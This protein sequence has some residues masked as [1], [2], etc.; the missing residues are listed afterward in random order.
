MI[1]EILSTNIYHLRVVVLS[2][3]LFKTIV[4]LKYRVSLMEDSPHESIRSLGHPNTVYNPIV[5]AVFGYPIGGIL[6]MRQG[7]VHDMRPVNLGVLHVL[8]VTRA[9]KFNYRK[10]IEHLSYYKSKPQ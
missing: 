4:L 7:F 6:Q 2:I 9:E 10:P 1:V 8:G 5:S 3:N